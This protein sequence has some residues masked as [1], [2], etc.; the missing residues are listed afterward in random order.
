MKNHYLI[1]VICVAGLLLSACA[2]MGRNEQ[3]GLAVGAVGGGLLGYAIGGGTG[4]AVG[5]AGGALAGDLIGRHM[6]QQG[7]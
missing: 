4:A 1:V 6:D 3:G 7:R 2:T 5:A